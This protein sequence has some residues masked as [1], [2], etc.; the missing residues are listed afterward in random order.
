MSTARLFGYL[1]ALM[2]VAVFVC[3]GAGIWTGD[4]RFWLL[5]ALAVLGTML[6]VTIAAALTDPEPTQ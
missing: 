6:S 4:T 3:A 2:L 5:T 1:A